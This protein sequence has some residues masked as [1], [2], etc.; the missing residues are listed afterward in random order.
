MKTA[1]GFVA[2][3]ALLGLLLVQVLPASAMSGNHCAFRLIPIG[4]GVAPNAIATRPELVGCFGSFAEAV[5]AGSGGAIRLPA[6]STPASLTDEQLTAATSASPTG[7][8]SVLIGTEWDNLN[9]AGASSSY[10]ASSTCTA[11]TTWEKSYVGDLLN[12]MFSSGKGFGGC[13]TNKKFAA[14]NFSG[15]SVTCT[16]NCSTYGTV[17]NLVSSL[18]W[19]I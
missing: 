4:R 14:S 9:Y 18:R 15:A 12:D 7:L 17:G 3:L 6:N 5:R 1:R 8:V 2:S 19:R 16:P 11:S 13:D 10:Y